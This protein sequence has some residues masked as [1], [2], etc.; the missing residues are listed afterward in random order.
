M[1]LGAR[2]CKQPFNNKI[3]ELTKIPFWAEKFRL[4]NENRRSKGL[5]YFRILFAN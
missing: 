2:L 5:K 3:M 1:N 4:P